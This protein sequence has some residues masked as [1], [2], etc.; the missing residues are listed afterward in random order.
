LWSFSQVA[1][2]TRTVKPLGDPEAVAVVE[3]VRRVL[4]GVVEEEE[5][6]AEQIVSR[7]GR[8]V[9][10]MDAPEEARG[11]LAELEAGLVAVL[12]DTSLAEAWLAGV[13]TRLRAE[14]SA[15]VASERARAER[16]ASMRSSESTLRRGASSS[17]AGGGQPLLPSRV[18]PIDAPPSALGAL[19]AFVDDIVRE[20]RYVLGGGAS[21]AAAADRDAAE[22]RRNMIIQRPVDAPAATRGPLAGAE[23]FAAALLDVVW[24][25]ETRRLERLQEA[26]LVR[27]PMTEEPRTPLGFLESLVVGIVRAPLLLS[28]LV[29]RVADLVADELNAAGDLDDADDGVG[30]PP[31]RR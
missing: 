30:T 28:A 1:R 26:G 6:R 23:R 31:D 27:R 3:R 8:A 12:N 7:G 25:T 14:V 9:R 29:T 24:D 2:A 21:D 5:F 16:G 15:I 18:R 4:G 13:A 17:S 19:E 11:P 20:A 22:S 10:P